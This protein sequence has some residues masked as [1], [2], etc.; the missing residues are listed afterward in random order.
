MGGLGQQGDWNNNFMDYA[1]MACQKAFTQGQEDRMIAVLLG[2]RASLL[3]SN[4]CNSVCSSPI[5]ASF[6]ASQDSVQAG[7]T[8]SFT[9]VS[10]GTVYTWSV[11][12]TSFSNTVSSSYTFNS[13]GSFIISYQVENGDPACTIIVYDTIL[14]TCPVISN[15]ILPSTNIFPG[16]SETFITSGT[17]ASTYQWVMDGLSVGSGGTYTETFNQVG[18]YHLCLI[19]GNGTCQDTS[20]NYVQIGLCTNKRA[21][22]WFFGGHLGLDFTTGIALVDSGANFTTEGASAISDLNGN[23]LFY[24]DCDHI[25]NANHDTLMNGADLLALSTSV[26]GSMAIRAP[27]SDSLYYLFTTGIKD[28]FD[29]LPPRGLRYH[30]IDMTLDGG[31]GAVIAKDILIDDKGS[32]KMTLTKHDN[33]VDYWLIMK[34]D[35][36]Y[37]FCAYIVSSLGVSTTPVISNIFMG[38]WQDWGQTRVS[39][40]GTKYFSASPYAGVIMADFDNST[41]VLSNPFMLSS[42]VQNYGLELSPN[43]NVL[44]AGSITGPLYQYDLT[45]GTPAAIN[46]TKI[47]VNSGINGQ[48][49][50]QLAPDGKIYMATTNSLYL[51][52]IQFPNTIGV[53]CLHDEQNIAIGDGS[54]NQTYY[55]LPDFPF[56]YFDA[57]VSGIIGES[58]GCIGASNIYTAQGSP[59]SLIWQYLGSGSMQVLSS[60]M[61]ELSFVGTGMDT[62][63]LESYFDCGRIMDTIHISTIDPGLLNLGPD[64]VICSSG[65]FLIDAGIGWDTYDWSTNETSSSINVNSN[66]TYIVEVTS[67]LGNC[68]FIDTI[69]V[70]FAQTLLTVDLGNDTIICDGGI[71][72]LNPGGIYDTYQWQD[73]SVSSSYTA[74][75]SGTYYVTVTDGCGNSASDTVLLTIELCDD[76][77]TLETERFTVFPNP[78]NGQVTIQT[79]TNELIRTIEVRTV[80]GKLV[81]AEMKLNVSRHELQL[82]VAN[83]IYFVVVNGVGTNKLVVEN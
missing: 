10:S 80:E 67:I 53:G 22:H 57:E 78:G 6:T 38:G 16:T 73:L 59:D 4:G 37:D 71:V 23:L 65:S 13:Q 36:S 52:A 81:Q 77:F 11:N 45:A 83:G 30:L 14:V 62:L 63:I 64:T 40:D 48:G 19:S 8:I 1:A 66:G 70:L 12:G 72:V 44:Y 20:C 32:E 60:S 34:R 42:S 18:G 75:A 2:P 25:Y 76:I 74:W 5:T 43:S 49:K 17:G 28:L 9:G 69:E 3:S 15:F 68:A 31:L 27:G 50:L 41:G 58:S 82:K 29:L 7:T 79:T 47:D 35:S 54:I 55:S 21:N 46:A 61:V 24:S 39:R 56:D 33:G 26:Q 51:G